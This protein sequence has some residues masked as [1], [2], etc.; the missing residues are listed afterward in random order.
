MSSTAVLQPLPNIDPYLSV[1]QVKLQRYTSYAED[2]LESGVED[3]SSLPGALRLGTVAVEVEAVD[4]VG[5]VA[6]VVV[7]VAAPTAR[8]AAVARRA[9]EVRLV[10][11]LDDVDVAAR[12][13][14]VFVVV[15]V[16]VAVAFPAHGNAPT[17][18]TFELNEKSFL[19]LR[20][21]TK[22]QGSSPGC[23]TLST[24]EFLVSSIN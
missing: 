16:G 5:V 22:V 4:L 17:V 19:S 8:D 7:V 15:A 23:L 24:N 13:R 12:W 3:R 9:L 11:L 10:A 18:G 21:S 2:L 20:S 6:A 14:L 1:R